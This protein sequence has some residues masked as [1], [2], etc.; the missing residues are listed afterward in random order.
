M[1]HPFE[2]LPTTPTSEE[3]IDKAFSRAAR[4]GKAKTGIEGQQSMLQ[5]AS[6]IVS[7]NLQNVV[8]SWPDIE[9]LDPFYVELADAIIV[10]RTDGEGGIDAI[11]QHLSEVQ[12]ASRKAKDIHREYQGRMGSDADTA[13]KLRKQAFAR[14]AD[15]VEEVSDDLAAISEA[16]DTLKTLPDI[17]P[18]EPTIVVAGYPNVGKSSFVNHVTNARNETASYPFTTT[19]IRVGHLER[20]RIRYQLVDTPGLLDRP[21]EE[22]NDI[23]SQAVSAVEHLADAVLVFLDPS[24]NCGYP[25]EVQL[26]LRDAIEARFDVPVLTIAN[27]SDLTTD[28]EA[29]HYMSV[30]EEDNVDGVLAAAIEAVGYEIELPF[31]E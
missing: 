28:V 11:K 10:S 12:W 14:I 3:V 15:V 26:E 6:N 16:R 7:D 13:R 22:R 4:A 25:L 21:E 23:E 17:K 29:D 2:D 18:D 24:G 20:D 9:T 5:T 27:K 19:Q 31:D 8:T 1:S 30:T